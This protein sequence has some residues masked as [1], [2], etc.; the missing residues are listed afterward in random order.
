MIYFQ[1]RIIKT[2]IVFYNLSSLNRIRTHFF[3]EWVGYTQCFKEPG[4]PSADICLVLAIK[5][6][7]NLPRA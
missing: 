5:D 3:L 6:D 2:C 7:R 4:K 1:N